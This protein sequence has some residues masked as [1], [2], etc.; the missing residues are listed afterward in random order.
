MKEKTP[1]GLTPLLRAAKNGHTEMCDLLLAN[2]SDLKETD[3]CTLF[4]ALHTA[5]ILGNQ[6]LLQ[7]L[8]SHRADV[9][10][11]NRSGGTPLHMASQEGH[12]ASVV[13]LLQAGADPL[14]PQQ[15][16]ALP[17]HLAAQHNQ[18][19]VVRI[20]IEQGGCSQDQVRHT[21]S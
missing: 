6:S 14:L 10:S 21:S 1:D 20:L 13:T 9:N 11:K 18:S 2:G 3:H 8:L 12:L 19:E 5:A 4:T 17:I 16:G 15:S 7:L